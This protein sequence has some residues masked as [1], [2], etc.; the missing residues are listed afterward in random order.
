M[1]NNID[2]ATRLE[3][4]LAEW[5]LDKGKEHETINISSISL[6]STD[7]TITITSSQTSPYTVTGALGASFPNTIYT[8]SS[9]GSGGNAPWLTQSPFSAPK[10]QLNGEGADVEVNGWSLVAAVKRI[11]ERLGLFQPNPELEQ[12]WEELKQ[13]GEQYRKLEQ[14]I[15]DKQA[16]WDRLK[17][18]P[19][20]NID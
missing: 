9:I 20:P 3:E 1:G 18:M 4:I 8:T 11:E 5:D 16:T 19:A 12:E 7:D 15:R 2:H 13:L 6:P 14:H 10:I 17:A